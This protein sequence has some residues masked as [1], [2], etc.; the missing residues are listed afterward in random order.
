VIER[1]PANNPGEPRPTPAGFLI[2]A[3]ATPDAQRLFDDDLEGL[4]YVSNVSRLWAHLPAALEALSDLMGVTTRAASLTYE[5]RSVLVTAAA[6]A[7]GDSYC[8]MAWGKKLAAAAS[9]EVA[10]AV[11]RG[12]VEGLGRAEQALVR[13]ARRVARGPNTTNADDVQAMREAGFEDPQIFAITVFVA[14]RLAFSIVNDALGAVPDRELAI[15][16][17][18]P[19]RSAVVF[20]R[21]PSAGGLVQRLPAPAS[22]QP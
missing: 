16:A 11:I 21:L 17:P 19:V 3:P 13:W 22:D 15:S 7:L 6:S 5:Q 2:A 12:R 18:E 8:S 1:T 9:P 14:L 20:G 4:G 10:A